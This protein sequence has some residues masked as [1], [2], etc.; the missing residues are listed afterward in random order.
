MQWYGY[1][2]LSAA[3]IS[4]VS[5]IQKRALRQEHSLQYVTIFNILKFFVFL[6]LFSPSL[7]L[8]VSSGQFFLACLSGIIGAVG[9]LSVARALRVLDI[10]VVLPMLALDPALVAVLAFLLLGERI[11]GFGALGISLVLIGTFVLEIHKTHEDRWRDMMRSPKMLVRPF[12]A[13]GKGRGG[14]SIVIALAAYAFSS[15]LDRFLLKQVSVP[16]YLFYNYLAGTALYLLLLISTRQKMDLFGSNKNFLFPLVVL[17]A[18]LNVFANV[19]QAQ[20]VS[21]AAVGLVIAVKRV[22]VLIDVALGGRLFHEHH[23]PQRL[24]ASAIILFGI[25]LIVLR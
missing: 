25:Y 1:A 23:L 24:L 10:S 4:L 12:I 20:A 6:L 22:S 18:V 17:A 14:A 13:I 19:A 7:S 5:I 21:L 11:T 9:L 3:L 15:I 2:L 8:N 16:T